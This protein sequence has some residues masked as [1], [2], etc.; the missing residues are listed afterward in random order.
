MLVDFMLDAGAYAPAKAHND[1]AGIDLRTPIDFSIGGCGMAKID[2]GIHVA[3][4]Q[5]FVGMIK[6]KSG[7]NVNKNLTCDGVIDAGYTGSIVVK[8]YNH[9]IERVFF[10]AGDKI[11][12]LVI[13]PI[14]EVELHE[15]QAFA[16][17]ERGNNGFGSTGK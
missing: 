4:P 3:I 13:L 7:L 15:V 12:Q 8:M 10:D 17:T 1:D 9:G 14:P 5:G 11:T 6:S 16:D 2:T